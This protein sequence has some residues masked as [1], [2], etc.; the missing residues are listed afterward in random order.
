MTSVKE[1]MQ[2][3]I[4]SEREKAKMGKKAPCCAMELQSDAN[5]KQFPDKDQWTQSCHTRPLKPGGQMCKHT[6]SP[7]ENTLPICNIQRIETHK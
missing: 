5:E 3:R 4:I 2:L 7:A 1:T 6:A